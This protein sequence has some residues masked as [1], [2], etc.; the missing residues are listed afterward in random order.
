MTDG[1]KIIEVGVGAVYIFIFVEGIGQSIL[2]HSFFMGNFLFKGGCVL[3][4]EQQL[5]R[6]III[7]SSIKRKQGA[8]LFVVTRTIRWL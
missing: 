2:E 3:N 8:E 6:T 1:L 4:Q 7:L 5:S